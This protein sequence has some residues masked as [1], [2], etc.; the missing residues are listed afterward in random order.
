VIIRAEQ[1]VPAGKKLIALTRRIK[2]ESEKEDS[3]FGAVRNTPYDLRFRLFGIPV[4]VTPWFWV[5]GIV[6]GWSLISAHRFDLLF[7]WVGTV[8]ISILVHEFGHA[9]TAK[10]FG[11]PPEIFLY[12]FGGLAI[13]RPSYGYTTAKSVLISFAGPAAGFVLY[14]LIR[15]CDYLLDSNN[16][17]S[18]LSDGSRERIFFFLKQMVFINLWWGLVNLLPVLPLDGGRIAE[19][20]L[21]RFRPWDGKAL[22]VKLSV[23][24]AAGVAIYAFQK[25]ERYAALMFGLLCLSNVQSMQQRGPW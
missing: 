21:A 20:L 14:G 4:N 3:M 2:E 6:L 10:A 11:W 24:V 15:L 1:C 12:E 16:A 8:F 7:I 18:D 13:F 19:S 22:A 23:V 17:L 5:A 9:F 25:G